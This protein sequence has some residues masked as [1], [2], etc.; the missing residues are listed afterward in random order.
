MAPETRA[1]SRR[2]LRR[3]EAQRRRRRAVATVAASFAASIMIVAGAAMTAGW[4]DHKVAPEGW[5]PS[6]A[7]THGPLNAEVRSPGSAGAAGGDA[8]ELAAGIPG[9]PPPMPTPEPTEPA[10]SAEAP[11]EDAPEPE[12]CGEAMTAAL[13]A[14]DASGAIEAAGGG[15]PFRAAIAAGEADCVPLADPAWPWV[16]VNKQRPIDPIDYAP[17]IASPNGGPD[18]MKTG[19]ATTAAEALDALAAAAAD[20]GAGDVALESGYRSYAAQQESYGSMVD[21][22][23][24][25]EA[26]LTS[27]R[28]GYSE[29]QLGLAA[30]VVAC[31]GGACGTIYQLGDTAQGAWIRENAWRWGWIVR[32]ESDQSGVTGYAPEP[33]HLRYVGPELAQAYHEG[34]FHTLEEFFGLPAAPGY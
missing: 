20:A 30:D 19:L 5:A 27:A 21:A 11:E 14:G 34:G 24:E 1:T 22:Y 23:G 13:G 17:E 8:E 33:W 9:T 3:R 12:I 7:G 18:H 16:V 4:T 28:P 25:A 2:A 15:E 26:D 29:H 31:E 10:E 32:Y 6:A